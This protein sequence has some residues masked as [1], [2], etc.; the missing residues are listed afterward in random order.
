MRLAGISDGRPYGSNGRS[1]L[2]LRDHD[3][4]TVSEVSLRNC[5]A[6]AIPKSGFERVGPIPGVAHPSLSR[7]LV[8][9]R[10]A[11]LSR[12]LL[13]A[14]ATETVYRVSASD[15]L[16]TV[17]PHIFTSHDGGRTWHHRQALA[18]TSGPTGVLPTA[19]CRHHGTI[20]VGEYPLGDDVP[21]LLGS[22]DGGRTWQ[23]VLE[24]P[25]I[26]HVHALQVDPFGGDIWITTGDTDVECHIGRLSV[27]GPGTT[28]EPVGGGSQEWRAVELAFTPDAV[29][30]G[31]DCGYAETNRLYRFDRRD[32]DGG[33]VT[34][35][36]VGSTT[37]SV[38][39][40]GSLPVDGTW[41]VAF[42]TAVETG[43]DRTNT[44]RETRGDDTARVLVA[45]DDSAFTSWDV[46]AA[47][48]RR[49]RPA[50]Y[51]PGVP[52]ANAY[53]YLDGD[54]EARLF[55]NPFNTTTANGQVLQVS[56]GQLDPLGG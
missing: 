22:M 5:V 13:G 4:D 43:Q 1:I 38:Y 7:R 29:L 51:L 24:L 55:L 41:W 56:P 21:R 3:E 46:L 33:E 31:V 8:T 37:N 26:R 34:P 17:G 27:D 10:L 20:Y 50:D 42:A 48:R 12:P 45:A 52:S 35:T 9:G 40:A 53:V 30:W 39:Y 47:F 18:P 44:D 2:S 14:V 54:P 32:L 19:I 28:F 16:A 11:S 36:Q 23:T 15:W 25:E 6:T 49:S